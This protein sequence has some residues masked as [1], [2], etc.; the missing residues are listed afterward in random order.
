MGTVFRLVFE[1]KNRGE[2]KCQIRSRLLPSQVWVRNRRNSYSQV[3][4]RRR[5]A[6]PLFIIIIIGCHFLSCDSA[7]SSSAA[8][9]KF[10]ME[11]EQRVDLDIS[12]TDESVGVRVEMNMAIENN[13][14]AAE[15]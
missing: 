2:A 13:E 5:L 8:G 4:Y 6:A 1:W 9:V 3:H 12:K 14:T 7:P 10:V 15:L 11:N